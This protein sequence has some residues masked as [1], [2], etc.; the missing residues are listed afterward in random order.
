MPNISDVTMCVVSKKRSG[1]NEQY[2]EIC[3]LSTRRVCSGG[4]LPHAINTKQTTN[5]ARQPN[6]PIVKSGVSQRCTWD[7]QIT[8]IRNELNVCDG[9]LPAPMLAPT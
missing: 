6:N 4:L 1:H 2:L 3:C 7:G 8:Q 5:S 9:S